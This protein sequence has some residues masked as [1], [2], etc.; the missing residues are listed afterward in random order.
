MPSWRRK[1][2][3]I[4][5]FLPG[6]SQGRGSLV[7]C[8]LWDHAEPDI[9]EVTQQQ[10]RS[11]LGV[12]WKDWCWSWN[13]NTLATS[14]E[15]L[16]HWKIP[17]CLEG[18]GAGGE[19]EDRGWD[20][21]MASPTRWT[22]VWGDSRSWWWTGRPGVLRFMGSQKVRHD[23]ATELNRLKRLLKEIHACVRPVT[24]VLGTG[25]R[26]TGSRLPGTDKEQRVHEKQL[27]THRNPK[28][29]RSLTHN[30][31]SENPK[32]FQHEASG[33]NWRPA[34]SYLRS[35]THWESKR[36]SDSSSVVFI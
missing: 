9:T 7:G 16:T 4:P 21:W 10:R 18:L 34:D 33:R 24:S 29:K 22:W 2:Q 31:V 12:H 32:C 14:C 36:P 17:W 23:W 13:S 28:V 20:G 1:W 26:S 6:E 30:L 15:K 5:V 27:T 8:C 19:G 25:C 35:H 3:P 11:V